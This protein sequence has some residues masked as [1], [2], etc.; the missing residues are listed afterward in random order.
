MESREAIDIN[1]QNLWLSIKR[2]WLPAAAV[3]GSVLGLSTVVAISQKPVYVAQGKL[4]LKK[5]DKAALTQFSP[6]DNTQLEP[7]TQEGNPANTEIEIIRSLGLAKKTIDVLKLKNVEGEHL[8][9][10]QFIGQLNLKNIP[11]TDV[12]QVAYES[13]NP[14]EAAAVV[15]KHMSL[16]VENNILSN[17]A[18]T[19][20]AGDFIAKQLPQTE[21]RLRKA[22]ASLRDFKEQNQVVN[23]D[24]EG[25][26]AVAVIKELED[27]ITATEA[28]LVQAKSRSAS[29]RKDIAINS[30][31]VI[32]ISSLNQSPGV[33][34]VLTE[35]QQVEGELVV[36]QTR[37]YDGHPSVEELKNKKASLKALL[38]SRIAQSLGSPKQVSDK[39]L[40]MGELKQKLTEDL[41][42]SEVERLSLSSRL[43]FLSKTKSAYQQRASVIPRLAQRQ[44]ELERQVKAAQATY[45]ILLQKLQEVRVEENRNIGNA[46]ILE[47]A[48]VPEQPV[49]GK[50]VIFLGLGT[51]LGTLLATATV[52]VLEIGDKSIKTP[53]EAREAFGY[54]LIALIPHVGKKVSFRNKKQ[55]WTTPSIL[56]KDNPRSLIA[57]NY[58]MLQANL[59]FLTSDRALK[60][61]V[62]TSSVPKEG[63]STVSAN[64]A[65]AIAQLGRRVL[66]VDADMRCP[67]QHHIWNL[68]NAAGLSNVI[69]SQAEFQTTV[70]E[71]MP[72]LHVL[73]A[74]VM[75]PNPMALLDSQRMASL[76]KHFT[77]LYDFV[78]VD[79]PP[80]VVAAD[81]LTLGKMTDGILFVARVGLL[82]YSSAATAKESL[83]C[84]CQNVLGVVVNGVPMEKQHYDKFHTRT[85]KNIDSQLI[86]SR[87]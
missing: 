35:L 38:Q 14:Q 21:V 44:G 84:S 7:L 65:A 69:V 46:S 6:A 34:K 57:E 4:L 68:T 11:S 73:S 19:A 47:T 76:V 70:Q 81:A 67:T 40:Q 9:P 15:N 78:I 5:S 8:K 24:E 74:G 66:L 27:Q 20:A 52:L 26:S 72:N 56:V 42:N 25:R 10:T 71:V 50:K 86:S 59:K 41:V 54:T 22:E 60:A 75:P 1:L 80:V 61:V 2:R 3:F 30:Q 77:Q 37:F 45:E 51:V 28:G 62:V 12:V 53:K 13:Q 36:L 39:D 83:D 18:Q 48:L 79:A 58:R 55:E 29:L 16:Y 82:D 85:S 64:L 31:N 32:P 87:R 49:G 63:K 33:Q 17:R 23:L 43:A